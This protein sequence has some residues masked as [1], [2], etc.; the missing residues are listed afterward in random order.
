MNVL[1]LGCSFGVPNYF[2]HPGPAPSEHT[3]FIL[4][5]YGHTVFNCSKN[6]S[7]NLESLQRAQRFLLGYSITHPAYKDQKIQI[8]VNQPID[9]IVWFHTELY[10]D[11]QTLANKTNNFD[12]DCETL[13]EITYQL[14]R[15]FQKNLGA[16]IAVIGGA[17]DLHAR[18]DNYFDP[19][20][21]IRSWRSEILGVNDLTSN[22][23]WQRNYFESSTAPIKEKLQHLE[24][25][26]KLLELT[27][28]S[29]DF[30][31]NYHPGA[32]P[33]RELAQKLH[34]IFQQ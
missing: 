23:I 31:D 5:D 27:H 4:R 25:D 24:T 22:T 1:L 16:R 3:E 8:T 33:H 10:R 9:W 7:S 11:L 19:E 34:Q 28:T 26:L 2:G 17:G 14:Y 29:P 21:V 20:F 15:E 30:P 13:A 12:K 32:R 18:F 6:G